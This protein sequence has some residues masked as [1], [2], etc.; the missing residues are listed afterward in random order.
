MGL[1]VCILSQYSDALKLMFYVSLF[2]TLVYSNHIFYFSHISLQKT[3][4][5]VIAL[6]SEI[7]IAQLDLF[8]ALRQLRHLSGALC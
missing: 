8:S 6:F 3:S 4:D 2:F 5:V 7:Y 1:V